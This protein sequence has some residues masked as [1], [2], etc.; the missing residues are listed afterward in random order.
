M[1]LRACTERQ[2]PSL[3]L[4]GYS[5]PPINQ[6]AGIESSVLEGMHSDLAYAYSGGIRGNRGAQIVSGVW[7]KALH[8][9]CKCHSTGAT[10]RTARCYTECSFPAS[11]ARLPLLLLCFFFFFFF[12]F[13]QGSEW[14]PHDCMIVTCLFNNSMPQSRLL[15][16]TFRW[17]HW[18]EAEKS[19]RLCASNAGCRSPVFAIGCSFLVCVQLP[20]S[21]IWKWDWSR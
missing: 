4:W 21:G 7:L 3:R 2:A 13:L 16:R 6:H 11:L 9:A 19:W 10:A 1:V 8:S 18:A 17:N 12:L 5:E 14:N 15:A 20:P